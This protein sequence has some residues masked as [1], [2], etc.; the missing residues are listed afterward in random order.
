MAISINEAMARANSISLKG[1]GN[2]WPNPIVGAV[3]LCPGLGLRCAATGAWPQG[4][5]WRAAGTPRA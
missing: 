5:I 2:T 3:L 1:L 4:G